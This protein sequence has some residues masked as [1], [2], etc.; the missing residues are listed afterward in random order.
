MNIYHQMEIDEYLASPPRRPSYSELEEKAKWKERENA[1]LRKR[2]RKLSEHNSREFWRG[3]EAGGK[4]AYLLGYW[5]AKE[6]RRINLR[7]IPVRIRRHRIEREKDE[8]LRSV[9]IE[10]Y[11]RLGLEY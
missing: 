9:I 11:N 8:R 2:M 1:S 7:Y 5:D 4:A 6:G 3:F 10:R